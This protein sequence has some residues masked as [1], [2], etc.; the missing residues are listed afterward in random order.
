MRFTDLGGN[1]KGFALVVAMLG[2]VLALS[3]SGAGAA[4]AGHI[5]RHQQ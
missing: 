1:M 4:T 2:G 3:A 5:T